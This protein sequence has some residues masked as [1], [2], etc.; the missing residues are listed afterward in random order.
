LIA[1]SKKAKIFL[2]QNKQT[3]KQKRFAKLY[4]KL[5]LGSLARSQKF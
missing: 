4:E 1:F 2:Q 5:D 3:N